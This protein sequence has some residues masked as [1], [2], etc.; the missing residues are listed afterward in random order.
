MAAGYRLVRVV[1]EG[2]RATVHLGYADGPAPDI[3]SRQAAVKVYRPG[4]GIDDI[5]REIACLS[6]ADHPHVVSLTDVATLPSGTPC[7]VLERLT[8]GSLARLLAERAE[9]SAGEAVTLVAPIAS[10]V[11][12]LHRSGVVHGA[13]RAASVAFRESGAPVIVGFGRAR[14][15][16]PG[17]SSA[18]LSA[19]PMVVAD[20]QRLAVLASAVLE[21]VPGDEARALVD[22]LA[23]DGVESD[24][25]GM[26]LADRMFELAA[27]EPVRLRGDDGVQGLGALAPAARTSPARMSAAH[28][29]PVAEARALPTLPDLM[30]LWV[31]IAAVSPRVREWTAGVRPRFWIAA[32]VVAA[33]VV[34][35]L[36]VV[37]TASDGGVSA[38]STDAPGV[39]GADGR[40]EAE[41]EGRATVGRAPAASPSTAPP[42]PSSERASDASPEDDPLAA[43][44]TLLRQRER[45]FRDLSVLCLDGVVQPGS[46]AAERD[47]ALIRALQD[48]AE[49]TTDATIVA[50]DP[51]LVERLGDTALISLGDV[52]DTQPASTLVMR[53]EAGWRIR[54]YVGG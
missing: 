32:G 25:Y 51:A 33:S 39:P 45:C 35:A 44:A 13:L 53:G 20:R 50:S 18:A 15:I 3:P 5:D 27:P 30:S 17:L 41:T 2:E 46:A 11:D 19:E 26:R 43:L 23:D 9:I 54:D 7:L 24:D 36:L 1:G 4:V 28:V 37:P 38:T 48:G 42:P 12:E 16:E 47:T 21:R 22:S 14:P 8:G 34:V 40:R 52:P 10:A 6:R 49:A 29:D 31:R